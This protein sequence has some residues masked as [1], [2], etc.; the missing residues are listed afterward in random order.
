MKLPDEVLQE[1][2]AICDGWKLTYDSTEYC[3][4]HSMSNDQIFYV[5]GNQLSE[6]YCIKMDY[7]PATNVYHAEHNGV[8]YDDNRSQYGAPGGSAE[9]AYENLHKAIVERAN[10]ILTMANELDTMRKNNGNSQ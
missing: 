2:N 6:Y 4:Q 9:E 1:L 8:K 3:T 5:F 10:K 7:H